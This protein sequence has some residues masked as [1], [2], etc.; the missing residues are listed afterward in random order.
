MKRCNKCGE[1]MPATSEFFHRRVKGNDNLLRSTCKE[2]RAQEFVAYNAA[3]PEKMRAIRLKWNA[4][5]KERKRMQTQRWA[6]KNL[7]KVR[8]QNRRY[9]AINQ[10]KVRE[11]RHEWESR[12]PEKQ[13]AKKANYRARQAGASGTHTA[14]DIELIRRTQ[15]GRC[16]YCGADLSKTGENVDHRVPLSRGGSNAPENLVIA[17]PTCNVRKSNKLPHEWNGRLL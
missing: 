15:K 4:N 10:D 6:S 1:L 5:H 7:E 3:H 16:W 11:W 2:C 13:H 17:C 14:A 9:K 12:N 8:E